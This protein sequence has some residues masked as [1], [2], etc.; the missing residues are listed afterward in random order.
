MMTQIIKFLRVLG[1]EASPIQISIAIGLAM[2]A[3]FTPLMSLHNLLVVFI[4]LSFRINLAAFLLSLGVFSSIAFLLDPIFHNI[5]LSLLQNESLLTYWTSM[6]NSN[7]WRIANFNNTILMGSMVVSLAAFVPM[8]LLLN[9][10]IKQYRSHILVY[11][12]NSKIARMLQSSKLF[13][14]FTS[15]MES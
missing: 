9:V 4:L 7:F 8:V 15:M 3:G 12:N 5:G 1:S 14:R 10:F 6:Y 11:I 2:I 13:T